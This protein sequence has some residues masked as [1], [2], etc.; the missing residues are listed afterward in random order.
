M[1]RHF[2][3]VGVIPVHAAGVGSDE[4][5][6]ERAQTAG[7]IDQS[8]DDRLQPGRSRVILFVRVRRR[9][10]DS[11][12]GTRLQNL[13]RAPRITP[14][15][16]RRDRCAL[17][18]QRQVV[19][20][21]PQAVAPGGYYGS[22]LLDLAD[23][24]FGTEFQVAD[25]LYQCAG[26]REAPATP[27]P[28]IAVRRDR[29]EQ[30]QRLVQ[31]QRTDRILQQ[32]LALRRRKGAQFS[33]RRLMRG[34]QRQP[35]PIGTAV[36]GQVPARFGAYA[37]GVVRQGG[38]IGRPVEL[39]RT[40][41]LRHRIGFDADTGDGSFLAFDQRGAGSRE[42]VQ[43]RLA[44]TNPEPVQIFLNQMRRKRQHEPIPLVHGAVFGPH[45]IQS[46]GGGHGPAHGV[47]SAAGSSD[48]L[49]SSGWSVGL[50]NST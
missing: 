28:A 38:R 46:A 1:R 47:T 42:R 31:R 49:V 20:H 7:I 6:L 27:L 29:V 33:A 32:Q 30:H 17:P 14:E 25:G 13:I 19:D 40:G 22:I 36:P 50:S 3:V 45:C 16:A 5:L 35:A 11:I 43:D 48:N 9:S 21:G 24:H 10:N 18:D 2:P 39:H 26:Q 41:K 8:E 12:D 34:K 4:V 15:H 44:G 23:P 37:G